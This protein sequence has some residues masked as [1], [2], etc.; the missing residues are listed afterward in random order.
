MNPFLFVTD[1]DNTLVGDDVAMAELNRQLDQ[2]RSEYGTQIVYSTGRSLTRYRQLT[3][4]KSLLEPDVLISG[5]GTEIYYGNSDTP[6]PVWSEKLSHRWDRD[7]VVA[8]AAHFADLTPQPET[9]Q[10]PFKVSYFLTE[11][12]AV[13]V[14][15]QLEEVLGDRGLDIQLIYS[16]SQDLDI[17]PRQANKGMA[18]TFVRQNLGVDPTR[19]VA[20]GDSGNDIALFANRQEYGIIVGNAMAELLQWHR[21]NPDPNRYLAKAHCAAGILEGLQHF[22]F[23]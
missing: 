23:L 11:K 10:R 21:T 1:L 16:G 3:A 18:M 12:A 4:E 20:C 13:E 9:E 19:T 5:V 22:G 2:H 8:C 15:P 6:D 7:E 14:L 17:L